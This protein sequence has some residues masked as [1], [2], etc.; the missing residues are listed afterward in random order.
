M[1]KGALRS[2][3][4]RQEFLDNLAA[5]MG[6]SAPTLVPS[7]VTWVGIDALRPHEEVNTTRATELLE[8]YR[9]AASILAIVVDKESK[10]VIDG[11]HRLHALKA[12]GHTKAPCVL[13]DCELG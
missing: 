5:E 10:V 12:L 8:Y 11:H 3:D 1:R 7:S 9:S 4:A 13:V 2:F 6:V